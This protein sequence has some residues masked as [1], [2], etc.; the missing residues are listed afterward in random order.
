MAD[1]KTV[2]AYIGIGC[3]VIVGFLAVSIGA[4]SIWGY[5]EMQRFQR[6]G[7]DPVAR[8][9]SVLEV[10]GATELPEGYYPMRALSVPFLMD[11][12][13]LTDIEQADD[14]DD[15]EFGDRGLLYVKMFRLGQNE[16]EL[17][18]Y[19]EGRTDD[20]NVLEDS[21]INIDVDEIIHRGA[22][23]IGDADLM[24]VIQRGNVSMGRRDGGG[25]AS[26]TLIECDSDSRMRIAIWFV[27][28]PDPDAAA[29]DLDMA[30]T[31]GDPEAMREFFAHFELC[32]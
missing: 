14:E 5:S 27:P 13:M 3:V 28:D 24:Y 8:R 21:G 9:D 20:A 32:G 18:D 12:A 10:L 19:F 6:E 22:M 30:G 17:R 1:G 7:R 4:C 26:M 11:L 16:E 2:F 29:V 15:P 25:L 23:E 31:P